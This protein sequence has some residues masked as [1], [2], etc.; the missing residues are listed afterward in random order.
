MLF[1]SD[2]QYSVPIKLSR[3]A[4]SIH[5]FKITGKLTPEHIK[6]KRNILWDIIELGWKDINMTLNGSKINLPASVIILLRDK[7]RCT[8]KWEP[9]LFHNIL[10][11]GMTLY[12]LTFG[13]LSCTPSEDTINVDLK[14]C[15]LWGIHTYKE[16]R[17]TQVIKYTPWG[18][19]VQPFPSLKKK[20]AELTKHRQIIAIPFA[21]DPPTKA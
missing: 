19:E 11:Q 16:D 9:L 1:I 15:T 4:G 2:T 13:I 5:S 20:M 8:V 10:K 6:L 12:N 14:I 7:I 3:I 17:S 21:T 18:T